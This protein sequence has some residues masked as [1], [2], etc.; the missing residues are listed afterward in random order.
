MKKIL[1]ITVLVL[2]AVTGFP[3]DGVHASTVLA[4]PLQGT[5]VGSAVTSR[6]EIEPVTNANVCSSVDG[7]QKVDMEKV[8]TAWLGWYNDARKKNGLGTFTYDANLDATALKWSETA[9]ERGSITH[10]RTGQTAYYDYK[11]MVSWFKNQGVSF[12]N[13]QGSTFVENIGWDYYSCP[14]DA[15][16][17]TDKLIASIKHTYNFFMGEKGKKYHAHYDSIM[18]KRY[19]KIGLGITVDPAKKRY[20]LTVHY[21]VEVIPLDDSAKSLAVC[22]LPGNG[23]F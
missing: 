20:Y 9:V 7:L 8:R 4:P 15:K 13:V 11:R 10:K 21:A 16:D 6:V 2:G 18:N 5:N 23:K 14:A 22:T 1:L 3:P 12:K 17:C 19:R